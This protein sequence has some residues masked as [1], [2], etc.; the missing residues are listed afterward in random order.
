MEVEPTVSVQ[1]CTERELV[2]FAVLPFCLCRACYLFTKLL[3]P[4]FRYWP[5]G[6]LKIAVHLDDSL[7]AENSE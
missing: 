3:H 7:C 1:G 6:G 4:L 2:L 5:S